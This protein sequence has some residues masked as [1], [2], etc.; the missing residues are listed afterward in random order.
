MANRYLTGNFAP[1]T[2]EVTATDL[3]VVGRIPA[4]LN[5]RYLRNGPNPVTPP[6]PAAYHWFEVDP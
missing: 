5:G 1:V 3:P 6:D 2:T 4:A